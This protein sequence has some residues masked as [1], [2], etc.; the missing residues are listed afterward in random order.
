MAERRSSLADLAWPAQPDAQ[1]V[2]RQLHPGSIL[3]VSAWP[4][5]LSAVE[6]VLTEVLGVRTP[7]L[8]EAASDPNL[9]LA[10]IAPGRFLV[11]GAAPDLV[12]RLQGALLASDAAVTDL[13]H[14]RTILRVEGPAAQKLLGRCVAL[15]LDPVAFP[16]GRVAQTSIHHVDVML[17]RVGSAAFQ[18]WVLRGFGE[19]LTEWILDAG[20]DLHAGFVATGRA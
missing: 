5:T 6:T 9:T 18:L 4:D 17:H 14:G 12:T 16:I 19:S 8:G 3:Q 1:T 15:D 7:R 11:A 2:L 10:A 20:A 13:E